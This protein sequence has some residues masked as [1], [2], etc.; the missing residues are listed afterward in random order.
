MV[1]INES[2]VRVFGLEDLIGKRIINLGWISW[3]IIGVVEDFY[4]ELFK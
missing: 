4:F 1:I 3:F 2:M